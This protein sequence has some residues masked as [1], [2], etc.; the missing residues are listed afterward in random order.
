M[1]VLPVDGLYLL[2]CLQMKQQYSDFYKIL[3]YSVRVYTETFG[4]TFVPLCKNASQD[5]D[6]FG[7]KMFVTAVWSK[8]YKKYV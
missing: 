7:M 3:F 8:Q 1:D 5:A 4:T 6:S 2:P